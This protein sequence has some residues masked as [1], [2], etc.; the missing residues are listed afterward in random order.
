MAHRWSYLLSSI[1][2]GVTLCLLGADVGRAADCGTPVSAPVFSK[3]EMWVWRGEKGREWNSE[4]IDIDEGTTLIR[5][6][7]GTIAFYDDQFVLRKIIMADGKAVT[8]QGSGAASSVGVK[9]FEFPLEI[10]KKWSYVRSLTSSAGGTAEYKES[11]EVL[12]CEEVT[13]PA[14]KFSALKIEINQANLT[15][16]S[17]GSF[18]QWYSPQ[19]KTTLRTTY[20]PSSYWLLVYDSELVKYEAK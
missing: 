5:Q 3:G 12:A 10:G 9:K 16:G 20:P 4:V 15:R 6:S 1:A 17:S 2:I 14:G 8:Q 13:T 18:F 7:N 19:V 11:Y